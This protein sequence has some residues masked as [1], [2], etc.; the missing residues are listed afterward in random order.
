MS[1]QVIFFSLFSFF[2]LCLGFSYVHRH[3]LFNLQLT[4]KK[5]IAHSVDTERTICIWLYYLDSTNRCWMMVS[6]VDFCFFSHTFTFR[7]VF[8]RT[9][10]WHFVIW[11]DNTPYSFYLSSLLSFSVCR[12]LSYLSNSRFL[13]RSFAQ[14]F[15]FLRI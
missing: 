1:N 14:S 7:F 5:L 2:F 6:M 15:A 3:C 13:S 10:R 8:Y 4:R 9:L 12:S 11:I